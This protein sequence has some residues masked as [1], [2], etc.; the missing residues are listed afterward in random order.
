[1]T[2]HQ[3]ILEA[4]K[5]LRAQIRWKPN[6]AMYHLQKRKARGHLPP[7]ATL[8]DY[9]NI[10]SKVLHD[11][12]AKVYRYWYNRVPYVTLTAAVHDK[13]WLVMFTHEG[14]LESCF[15]LERTERYMN[16]PGFEWIGRLGEVDHE[17]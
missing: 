12:S 9:E 16:K 3:D 17:L 7:N 2:R 14:I 11:K 15:V 13:Q 6:S 10:I 4:V 8:E 1:M 5:A